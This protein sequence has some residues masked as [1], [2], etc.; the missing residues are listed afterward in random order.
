MQSFCVDFSVSVSMLATCTKRNNNI[1]YYMYF[2][3]NGVIFIQVSVLDTR[4]GGSKDILENQKD[5][6][7]LSK[8]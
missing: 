8:S 6:I 2:I 7:T 1:H 4:G 5:R 3:N